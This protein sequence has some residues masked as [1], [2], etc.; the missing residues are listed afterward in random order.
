MEVKEVPDLV[1]L[2][3][4]S[5]GRGERPR[6][7]PQ[8]GPV[9]IAAHS[10]R[11]TTAA[12]HPQLHPHQHMGEAKTRTV[13]STKTQNKQDGFPSQLL[14]HSYNLLKN[15]PMVWNVML[16]VGE[17]PA[18]PYGSYSLKDLLLCA[19]ATKRKPEQNNEGWQQDRIKH[20]PCLTHLIVFING[21]I[22]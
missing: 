2:A 5:Q 6:S 12:P 1:R 16:G 18:K 7:W 22:Q 10:H 13:S 3:M 21:F 17:N 19:W 11:P 4:Q 14:L 8:M 20:K 15:P 9:T